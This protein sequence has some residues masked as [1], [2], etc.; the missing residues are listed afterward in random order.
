[1]K[2]TKTMN[3]RPLSVVGVDIAQDDHGRYSLNDLHR[4][5]GGETRHQPSDFLRSESVRAFIA[6]AE[7]LE[8]L[9]QAA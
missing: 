5:A 8:A 7:K 1:M 3:A 4:A 2:E 9:M 6:D